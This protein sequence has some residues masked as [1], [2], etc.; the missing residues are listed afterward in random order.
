MKKFI[1]GIL[2]SLIFF[3]CSNTKNLTGNTS[4]T[5]I[6]GEWRLVSIEGRPA[7]TISSNKTPFIRIDMTEARISGSTGCN[8]FSGPLKINANTVD[9]SQPFLMTKMFCEGMDENQFIN[10]LQR[11][12]EFYLTSTNK[13]QLKAGGSVLMEFTRAA[14]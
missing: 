3:S 13:L 5:N 4:N 6:E 8:S 12:N 1:T 11:G 2:I 7:E 9:L 14:K 10:T